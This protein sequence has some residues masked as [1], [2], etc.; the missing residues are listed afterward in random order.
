M[1][2][3]VKLALHAKQHHGLFR[4]RHAHMAGLTRGQIRHR[5]VAG[6][7]EQIHRDVFRLAGVP[8][9]WHG[10]ILAACWAGGFRAV[11]SHRCATALFAMPG[12]D[13]R[14]VEIMCPRWRR[15]RHDGLV[16]HETNSLSVVDMTV[17]DGI[18]VTTPARTLF[19]LGRYRRAGVVELALEH[20][21]R[22]GLVTLPEV[23]ATVR[24]L[25]RSGR[26]G[27]P[28]LR[29]VLAARL[30]DRRPTESDMETRLLQAIRRSGLPDPVTQYEVWAGARFVARVDLAYP[31]ARIAIE[32]DSDAFHTGRLATD[33]DRSRRHLLL[34]AGWVT[35]DV[36]AK[37]LRNGALA[38]C[39]AIRRALVERLSGDSG[40][41]SA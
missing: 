14:L 27:G 31:D 26:P 32:Y 15:A 38:A 37:D 20:A 23:D 36:G 34:A 12:G 5:I 22:R 33:R 35:V 4:T 1:D 13:R 18:P 29:Q 11:A 21:L 10:E 39:A 6:R 41:T 17:I 9:T 28:V 30:P 24:R 16:V 2:M 25:G 3:D 19:D 7:W 40:V 8:P